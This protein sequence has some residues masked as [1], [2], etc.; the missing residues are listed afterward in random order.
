MGRQ[1]FRK[2]A[3]ERLSSP[4]QLDQLMQAA[5]PK[6]WVALLTLLFLLIV[7]LAWSVMGTIPTKVE[8]QGILVSKDALASIVS[9][10]S[11][12]IEKLDVQLDDPIHAGQVVARLAQPEIAN[13]LTDAKNALALQLK[14]RELTQSYGNEVSLLRNQNLDEQRTTLL[15]S[16]RSLEN[17]AATL[18]KSVG[19][20]KKLKNQGFITY[21]EYAD[22]LQKSDEVQQT[23]NSTRAQLTQLSASEV[24][25]DSQLK[26]E[27]ITLDQRIMASEDEVDKLEKQLEKST[28][29]ISPY[30]GRVTE[31]FKDTG[32]LIDKGD[33]LLTLEQVG[34]E[35]KLSVIAYFPPY[36]GKQI[37]QGMTIGIAPSVIRREEFGFI[38]GQVSYV[39][40]FPASSQGMLQ[41]LRNQ[42]LV[43]TLSEGGPPIMVKAQLDLDPDTQS[44]FRWSSGDGPDIAI[45]SGTLCDINVVVKEQPPITLV[46]PFLK[47]TFLGVGDERL[48]RG[49]E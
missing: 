47:R 36:E 9:V 10:S 35:Q 25:E 2:V 48:Q 34:E 4:E 13:Q 17:R 1:I 19:H 46:L 20:Y 49:Q 38:L 16:L 24:D 39:S 22:E 28:K 37:S 5:S 30:S 12:L 32:M 45:H 26:K 42:D 23:I 14:E 40:S 11:G 6:S 3:L 7:A 43:A 15:T 8:G 29:I 41:T 44:G 21:K 18:R 27:I 31:I 33:P